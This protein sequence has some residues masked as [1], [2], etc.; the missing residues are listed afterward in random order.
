LKAIL[1]D[2]HGNLEAL[3]AVLD[4]IDQ[5]DVD[6]V[7]CLG[8]TV[9]YGPNPCEC[10]DLVAEICSVV[11]LGNHDLATIQDI[12]GFRK[13]AED[14]LCWTRTQLQAPQPDQQ[15][16]D[17]RR[18]F[19]S[20]CQSR[21]QDGELLFVHGSPRGPLREY[22]RAEDVQD[23][24]KMNALFALVDRCCFQGHTH[25][26]GVFVEGR[27][28]ISPDRMLTGRYRLDER[29]VLVNV[30]SVGQPRD[31]DWRASYVL[32]D[33]DTIEFRRVEYDVSATVRKVHAAEL[34]AWLGDRLTQGL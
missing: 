29:K 4:D 18:G 12:G 34:D 30:G 23:Q 27:D 7:Y 26:P 2:I 15:A 28:F 13:H 31:G 16:A 5:H 1:S 3:Y 10:L 14:A 19:L 32:F 21:H 8:D 11:L 17:R 6:A 9:G 24:P 33:G 22:V 20:R 25:R